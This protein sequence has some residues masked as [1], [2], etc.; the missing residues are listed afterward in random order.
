MFL[1]KTGCTDP[2]FSPRARLD[3][4]LYNQTLGDLGDEKRKQIICIIL[5][6]IVLYCTVLYCIVLYCT[7]LYCIVLYCTVLYCTVL[8]CIVLY[9]IATCSN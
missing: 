5:Y 3:E 6:C 1:L 2:G 7:V 8:Y 4:A 9:C